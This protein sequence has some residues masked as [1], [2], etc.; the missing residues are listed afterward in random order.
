MSRDVGIHSE[1]PADVTVVRE[2]GIDFDKRGIRV[3]PGSVC[4]RLA[5][6]A[7]NIETRRDLYGIPRARR[8]AEACAAQSN[9]G[10]AQFVLVPTA[11]CPVILLMLNIQSGNEPDR[12]RAAQLEGALIPRP[13]PNGLAALI[14]IIGIIAASR[15]G[16]A[17]SSPQA[18]TAREGVCVSRRQLREFAGVFRRGEQI[19]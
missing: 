7:E 3:E 2:V 8:L 9:A 12:L 13:D 14:L 19:E 18:V 17:Q 10:D 6:R 5:G 15:K 16:R 1:I 11:R 4:C